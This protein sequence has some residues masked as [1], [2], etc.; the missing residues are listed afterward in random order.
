MSYR[1]YRDLEVWQK[2]MKLVEEIY[3]ITNV[4]P[5][6]EKYGLT[7]QLRRAAISVPSNIA[8]GSRRSKKEFSYFLTIAFGS[9]AEVETQLELAQ[10][11]GFVDDG[12][13]ERVS[14]IIEDVMKMLNKMISSLS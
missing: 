8:E 14:Q 10:R 12:Q 4:F 13:Y 11:F 3:E 2:S 5:T 1:G 9:G 7:S 6:E